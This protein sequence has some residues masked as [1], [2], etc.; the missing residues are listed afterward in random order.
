MAEPQKLWFWRRSFAVAIDF[1]AASLIFVL[2]FTLVTSGTSDTLRLS[3]FGIVTRSCGP[4]KVSPA[5]L[6]AGN[7]A[8]PGV[9]WTTAAQCN[10]SSFGITQN[11]IIVLARSE[12]QKNSVVITHS[13]SVPVDTAG[14]P[15]SPFYLDSLGLL[16]FLVAGLIFLASRLRATP[17]MKLMGLQLV[18][19]DGERAGL[20]AVFLRLVYAYIPVVLVI[21]LGIGT[22]LLVGA[23]NLSAWLL[24]PAFFAAV[25]VALSWWRP[26]ELRRSLPRAP[27]HDIWAST[28][29]VRAAPQPAVDLTTDTAR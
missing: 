13:V 16:L 25:I 3:G 5:V 27:L 22:F 9:D 2:A 15:A 29:I 12:K 21:A 7:E 20:K 17:G 24:A 26:F 28:R 1:V 8:M 11:H 14:N 23:Y 18:T 19:A 4:A 6:A 10:I